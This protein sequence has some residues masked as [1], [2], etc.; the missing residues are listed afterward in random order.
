[1]Y[2]YLY[3]YN[4]ACVVKSGKGCMSADEM[5]IYIW[6]KARLFYEKQGDYA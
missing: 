4:I 5:Y 2:I 1:M 6:W 3:I